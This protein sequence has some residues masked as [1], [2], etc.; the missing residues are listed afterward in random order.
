MPMGRAGP[1][2]SQ[3][4]CTGQRTPQWGVGLAGERSPG[5]APASPMRAPSWAREGQPVQAHLG[6]RYQALCMP[7][8]ARIADPLCMPKRAQVTIITVKILEES[9]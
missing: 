5:H 3:K 9:L 8:W 1:A 7:K 4:G 2:S 6:V